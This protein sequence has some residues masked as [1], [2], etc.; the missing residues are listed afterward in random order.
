MKIKA[1]ALFSG[2]LDSILA[3]KLTLEEGVEVQALHFS[4]PFSVSS[5]EQA[6]SLLVKV[7]KQLG[8][9]LEDV[10]L[11]EEY[12]RIIQKP[13]HGYGKNLNP[14]IDCRIYMLKKAKKYME[15]IGA[16]FLITGEVVGQRPMSQQRQTLAT[17][18]KEADLEGFILRPLSAKLL[19]KTIPEDKGWVKR[20]NLLSIS[21]RS[22][23]EQLSLA[24][25]FKIKDYFW[26]G[27]GCLLTDSGFSRRLQD[28]VRSQ[29][30]ELEE[31]KLLRLG[32][33]FRF[34]PYFRFVVGRN[35]KENAEIE[36]LKKEADFIFRPEAASGPT[37]LGR[38]KINQ[39]LKDLCV[40]IIARYSS[41]EKIKVEI[42]NSREKL[43]QVIIA[44]APEKDL[45]RKFI[46]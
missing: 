35:K 22:R 24:N 6:E 30:L 1:V 7:S 45:Y 32:R 21:G 13:Q 31:I 16:S 38:G 3:A 42:L 37:G 28:I 2:G 46:V 8:I 27:G 41:G 36:R 10:K 14:C 34:T 33:H 44:T 18:E 17:I 19:G 40:K 20:E 4:N 12:L 11:K 9:R 43:K 26:A 29:P 25:R 23:K 39:P 15:D 5:Q